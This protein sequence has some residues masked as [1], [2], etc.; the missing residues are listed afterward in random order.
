MSLIETV[1]GFMSSTTELKVRQATDDNEMAGATGTL[2][3]EISVLTY[4]K[5]TLKD[6]TQVIRKR[7]SGINKKNNHKSCL[8]VLKT[9]TLVSYLL[10]NGSNDFIAWLKSTKYVIE[11]LS[12]FEAQAESDEPM[13]K[14]IRYLCT[15]ICTLLEDEELLEKR[16][17]DV[18]QFRSSIS[19]PG[20]KSTDNSHI[21]SF[22]RFQL[23]RPKSEKFYGNNEDL[24]YIESGEDLDDITGSGDTSLKKRSARRALTSLSRTQLES[25]KEEDNIPSKENSP[26]KEF[27]FSTTNPFR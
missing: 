1:R 16:R 22:D 8:H 23:N 15:D 19:S 11:Y 26:E 24:H 12:N 2:M 13:V 27:R 14:Q 21:K 10:N 5:K 4:S 18:I 25:L 7:L 20:R 9:L 17:R 6:V 3:N